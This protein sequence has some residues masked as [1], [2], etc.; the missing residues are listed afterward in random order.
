VLPPSRR[1]T[2]T[3]GPWTN[4]AGLEAGGGRHEVFSTGHSWMFNVFVCAEYR[5]SPD[6][7]SL[8]TFPKVSRA[9]TLLEDVEDQA[10]LFASYL[11]ASATSGPWNT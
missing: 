4:A 11:C 6:A 2:S 7:F 8:C 1:C 9:L 10:R 5:V 3:L